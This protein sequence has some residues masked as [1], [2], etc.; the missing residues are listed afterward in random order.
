MF[1]D[2]KGFTER[3]SS[4]SREQ[5]IDLLK[6]HDSVLLPVINRFE[7]AVIKTIGDAFLVTFESPTNAVLCGIMLQDALRSFNDKKEEAEKICIRVAIN[8]GEV[9]IRD[10]DVFGEAV[11]IAARL[12]GITDANE[13]YFTESVYLA[14]NK[15]EVP[16][17]E[18]GAFRLKGIPEAIKVYRVIQDPCSGAYM[19]M[20]EKLREV[21]DRPAAS[22]P[23]IDDNSPGAAFAGE[24]NRASQ[25][26]IKTVL[27]IIFFLAGFGYAVLRDT[28]AKDFSRVAEALNCSD[29]QRAAIICESMSKKYPDAP[30]TFSA[31]RALAEFEVVA[32]IKNKKFH[33][34]V[35]YIEKAMAEKPWMKLDDLMKPALL[36][37]GAYYSKTGNY[38]ISSA[39]YSKL[40]DMRPNDYE[41]NLEI[42][43]NLGP[44]YAGGTTLLAVYS[45]IS[46]AEKTAGA[47]DETVAVTLCQGLSYE[48]PKS[49]RAVKIRKF[50]VERYAK[51]GDAA[52][53]MTASD[54]LELRENGFYLLKELRLLKPED[55]FKRYFNNLT[56]L[57]HSDYVEIEEA[58]KYF[59]SISPEAASDFKKK[60]GVTGSFEV[61][62]FSDGSSI[63]DSVGVVIAKHF[64]AEMSGN[65]MKW[66]VEKDELWKRSASYAALKKAG[67]SDRIDSWRFHSLNLEEFEPGFIPD[68][69][70]EALGFFGRQQAEKKAP[71]LEIL[72][73]CL[74]R[75]KSSLEKYEYGNDARMTER[76]RLNIRNL[77]KTIAELKK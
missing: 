17:S 12:E 72:N 25:K 57:G 74:A 48:K 61:K 21:P 68:S 75:A 47:L 6:K 31:A 14:M 69:F 59:D 44:G 76:C 52:L 16:S 5:L 46:V 53:K 15:A 45:A 2:I 26:K 24:S 49:D 39:A 22:A 28:A 35:A 20:V 43:N 19:K 58:V 32:L 37:M 30:E 65:L 4:A 41:V 70:G 23:R 64:I 67:L 29:I 77:E 27:V 66:S 55:E 56:T 54:R 38:A 7:G 63:S 9:E 8:I 62:I 18:V 51:S 1:T 42:I 40:I 60:S 33:E 13:I 36:A 71:A 3:T 34:A 73:N 50:L 11:N 10:G